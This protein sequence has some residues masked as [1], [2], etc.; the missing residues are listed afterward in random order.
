[1]Q[2]E[3]FETIA[4]NCDILIHLYRYLDFI[5]Q[6]RLSRVSEY[7][8]NIFEH[9]VWKDRYQ[10]MEITEN[11][12]GVFVV[13]GSVGTSPLIFYE[14]EEFEEFL[15]AYAENIVELSVYDLKSINVEYI[16]REFPK[17]TKLRYE[18]WMEIPVNHY[19][20]LANR[21]PNLQELQLCHCIMPNVKS[22]TRLQKLRRLC[23][24][25][26]TQ[27]TYQQFRQ[28]GA[29]LGLESLKIT[30]YIIPETLKRRKRTR[31][32][33]LK[34]LKIS[35][36]L[37]PQAWFPKIFPYFLRN[38]ENLQSLIIHFADESAN[39]AAFNAL[40]QS[41][42]NLQYLRIIETDFYLSPAFTLP[43]NLKELAVHCGRNLAYENL[44]EF[45]AHSK[46]LKFTSIESRYKGEW[47]DLVVSANIKSL[48]V[49]Y[50]P[51]AN[52]NVDHV[53]EL[54]WYEYPSNPLQPQPTR[55]GSKLEIL[56]IDSG[57]LSL[58]TLL[59]L[60]FLHTLTIPET[61]TCLDWSYVRALL[62]HTP[63][64]HLTISGLPYCSPLCERFGHAPSEGL[65]IQ[66]VSL[67]ISFGLLQGALT[68][69]LDLFRQNECLQLICNNFKT[70]DEFL[71]K[72]LANENFP[73][74]LRNLEI[75]GI[76]LNCN[77]LRRNFNAMMN[78]FI[79]DVVYQRKQYESDGDLYNLVLCRK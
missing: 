69:W 77:R 52:L 8:R 13:T 7:L 61:M 20:C 23:I 35:T 10:K 41:C 48:Q 40:G 54:T 49:Q 79:S 75:W 12:C 74:N 43:P 72:L 67:K 68:F 4:D 17:L 64:R 32:L 31:G 18:G 19:S 1:M 56:K 63:L 38:F 28:F 44:K 21:C 55:L 57:V 60:K 50:V 70:F 65:P 58:Q 39:N 2:A 11:S 24:D 9:L 76:T 22:L 47:V 51:T 29:R 59:E 6:L 71:E 46:L 26:N 14:Y 15:N 78:K 16:I 53:E 34:E 33:P 62:C 66:L 37:D 3:G 25:T 5:D 45:L 73:M 42:G 30:G 36:D 27:F